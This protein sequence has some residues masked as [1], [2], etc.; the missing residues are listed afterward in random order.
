MPNHEDVLLNPERLVGSRD[1]QTGAVFFPFRDLSADGQLRRCERVEL[2]G[3][4][5]LYSWTRFARK[6]FGQIDLPEG[7]RIQAL[8]KGEDHEI[9]A[10]YHLVVD[11][12]EDGEKKWSF[13]R[14]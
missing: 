3:K 13:A 5:T 8:L 14:V 12:T 10:T 6:S 9:G 2:T 7:V 11:V 4:G 1:P